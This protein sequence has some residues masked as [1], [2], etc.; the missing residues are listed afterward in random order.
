[1]RKIKEFLE[2]QEKS[3]YEKLG[4][5]GSELQL[6]ISCLLFLGQA[7]FTLDC[8]VFLQYQVSVI[9]IT[10]EKWDD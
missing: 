10:H 8:Q 7:T 1:M 9:L 6:V 4:V 5:K 2:I 3:I